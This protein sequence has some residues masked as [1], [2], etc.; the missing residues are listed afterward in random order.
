MLE[1]LVVHIQIAHVDR[2]PQRAAAVPVLNVELGAPIDQQ[3][4]GLHAVVR[5]GHEQRRD[6]V[7]LSAVDIGTGLQQQLDHGRMAFARGKEQRRQA[8]SAKRSHAAVLR[9]AAAD[10]ADTEAEA[11]P[12]VGQNPARLGPGSR[13]CVD[14]GPGGKQGCGDIGRAEARGKHQRRL[15]EFRVAGAYIRPKL[16]QRRYGRKLAAAGGRHEHRFADGIAIVGIGP[17]G[18]QYP[19]HRGVTVCRGKIKRPDTEAGGLLGISACRE[20]LANSRVLAAL[21]EPV[22]SIIG[23]VLCRRDGHAGHGGK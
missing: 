1:S 20:L 15:L 10:D 12:R 17:G 11:G 6:A 18:N 23:R 2:R 22:Q 19:D 21:D 7:R 3:L 14:H 13:A 4:G 5:D 16:E 9:Q 8:A